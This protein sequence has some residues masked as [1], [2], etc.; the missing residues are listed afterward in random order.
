MAE[1]KKPAGI[2][3]AAVEKATGKSWQQWLLLLD[4]L[5]CRDQAHKSIAELL[6]A[7][8]Q[9]DGWWAQMITVGYEQSRGLR[10]VLEHADGFAANISRTVNTQLG[11]LY[12][13]FAQETA[14]LEQEGIKLRRSKDGKVLRARLDDGSEL[15]VAIAGSGEKSQV[16]V[17]HSQLKT[18]KAAQESKTFW[19]LTLDELQEKLSKLG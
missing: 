13:A 5:G 9:L 2:S 18:A 17:E 10:Q 15:E 4:K 8:H 16:R 3:S 12:E 14:R 7:Q 19:K 1:K 11:V 6:R